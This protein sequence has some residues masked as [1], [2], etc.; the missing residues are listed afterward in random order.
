M[1]YVYTAIILILH[2]PVVIIR[3]VRWETVQT[4]CLVATFFTIVVTVQSFVSTKFAANQILTWTPLMLVID[5]GRY[6]EMLPASFT[7]RNVASTD[8]LFISMSQI[9]FLVAEEHRLLYRMRGAIADFVTRS[10]LPRLPSKIQRK[11]SPGKWKQASL[12]SGNC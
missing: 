4:W 7:P 11:L 2:I 12:A 3:V 9:I 6:V 5:A 8:L 10:I 1:P